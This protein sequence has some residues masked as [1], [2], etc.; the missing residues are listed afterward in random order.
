VRNLRWGRDW[1][2]RD[3]FARDDIWF[4]SD[5]TGS[6]AAP[7]ALAAARGAQNPLS[8]IDFHFVQAGAPNIKVYFSGAH[9]T[10]DG[11]ASERGWTAGERGAAMAAFAMYSAATPLHFT[12]V[13]SAKH[14]RRFSMPA[15]CR[16]LI[17]FSTSRC[18][19]TRGLR[20]LRS[21]RDVAAQSGSID[22]A[23]Q[24]PQRAWNHSI[25]H[26]APSRNDPNPSH[27][28]ASAAPLWRLSCLGQMLRR[29]G[30]PRTAYRSAIR[31]ASEPRVCAQ[32]RCVPS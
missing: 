7:S 16:S 22:R 28:G 21:R 24:C 26:S 1:A 5:Q 32:A 27:R 6:A 13:K 19:R 18:I 14:D 8:T 4:K 3:E 31:N 17:A 10:F 15:G 20:S 11:V 30:T 23:F 9:Q 2:E 29:P 25:Q 12:A